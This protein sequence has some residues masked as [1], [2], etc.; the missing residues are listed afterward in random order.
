MDM[1]PSGQRVSYRRFV[2]CLLLTGLHPSNVWLPA[3]H[4]GMFLHFLLEV[5][6]LLLWLSFYV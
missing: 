1:L 3:G 2:Q 6:H 5:L 4:E